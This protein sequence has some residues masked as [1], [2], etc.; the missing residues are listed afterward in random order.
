M[1]QEFRGIKIIGI[2]DSIFGY[3]FLV[4]LLYCVIFELFRPEN[5]GTYIAA[6]AAGVSLLL[7]GIVLIMLGRLILKLNS[8]AR[9]ANIFLAVLFIVSFLGSFLQFQS[10][11]SELLKSFLIIYFIWVIFYLNCPKVTEQFKQTISISHKVYLK[12]PDKIA[13][14]IFIGVVLLLVL[15]LS[16]TV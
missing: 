9:K 3:S 16:W 12:I 1:E 6:L 10:Q 2:V 5:N 4:Y 15:V 8:Q 7:I 14:G 13:W 11:A